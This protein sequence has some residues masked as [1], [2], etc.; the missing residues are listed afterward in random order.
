MTTNIAGSNRQQTPSEMYLPLSQG[1]GPS[2]FISFPPVLSM[3]SWNP[4]LSVFTSIN[5]S[6]PGMKQL[7]NWFYQD[8]CEW[9][10]LLPYSSWFWS[11]H[12]IFYHPPLWYCYL[13]CSPLTVGAQIAE[14]GLQTPLTLDS[15]KIMRA[16][17]EE[18][19]QWSKVPVG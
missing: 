15:A 17:H 13:S 12:L 10:N 11:A 4:T 8:S 1:Q 6:A 9:T 19:V 5:F 2:S 16:Q 3:H 7:I 18:P 14:P